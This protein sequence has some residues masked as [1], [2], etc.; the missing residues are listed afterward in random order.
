MLNLFAS[1]ISKTTHQPLF[2]DY[3]VELDCIYLSF[4]NSI[5]CGS[6]LE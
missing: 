1:S 5:F 3:N 4:D 6:S 2:Y